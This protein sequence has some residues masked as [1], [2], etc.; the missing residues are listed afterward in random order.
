MT[1]KQATLVRTGASAGITLLAVLYSLYPSYTWITAVIAAAA[2]LGIHAIPAIGQN[3]QTGVVTMS[4]TPETQPAE[5]TEP[6]VAPAQVSGSVL[7]GLQR[8]VE[9]PEAPEAPQ[10]V[11]DQEEV[12]EA[13]Q[14]APVTQPEPVQEAPTRTAPVDTPALTVAQRLRAL[15]DELETL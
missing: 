10:A 8:P 1:T 5:T 15:A 3:T 13:P 2:T 7:M 11:V 6:V 14:T 9:V 12:P 4:E